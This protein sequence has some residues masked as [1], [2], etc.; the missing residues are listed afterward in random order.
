MVPYNISSYAL[1]LA[2]IAKECGYEC[3]LLGGVFG[4]AHIYKDHL[5][6]LLDQIN[7][8]VPLDLPTLD[9]SETSLFDFDAT[10]VKLENYNHYS[11][12]KLNL[13]T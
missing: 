3:G 8:R 7:E 12:V 2:L 10:K 1:L 6:K 11:S 4:D 9:I 13:K 5:P